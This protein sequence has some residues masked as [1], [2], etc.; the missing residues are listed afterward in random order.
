MSEWPVRRR[1]DW[2]EEVN[3]PQTAKDLAEV[4]ESTRRG[5]PFGCP[6]WQA[7]TAARLKLQST[8]RPAGRPKKKEEPENGKKSGV[9][10]HSCR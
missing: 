3:E 6:A 5:R 1:A 4:R 10:N 8:F 7:G 9:A 2:L